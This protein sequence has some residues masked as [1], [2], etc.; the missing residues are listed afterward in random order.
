M[1]SLSNHQ[2]SL[3]AGRDGIRNSSPRRGIVRLWRWLCTCFYLSGNKDFL[4]HVGN[5]VISGSHTGIFSVN[6]IHRLGVIIFIVPVCSLIVDISRAVFAAPTR[7]DRNRSVYVHCKKSHFSV[8]KNI[9]LTAPP[10]VFHHNPNSRRPASIRL[11]PRQ[12]HPDTS[13]SDLRR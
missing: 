8:K 4:K 1:V 13:Q 2:E 12:D 6:D 11:F 7:H 3:A 10:G 9:R 5:I